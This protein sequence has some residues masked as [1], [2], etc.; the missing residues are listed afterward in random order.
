MINILYCFYSINKLHFYF[1][2]LFFILFFFVFLFL[3]HQKLVVADD[4]ILFGGLCEQQ[5]FLKP[6]VAKI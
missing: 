5:D 1:I 4:F 2:K 6:V 3:D